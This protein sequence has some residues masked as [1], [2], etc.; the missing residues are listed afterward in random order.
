MLRKPCRLQT[1]GRTDGQTDGRGESSIPP[2]PPSS[3]GGGIKMSTYII[4]RITSCHQHY[5]PQEGFACVKKVCYVYIASGALFVPTCIVI[6]SS[7]L[8]STR[9]S[10]R[11]FFYP[12]GSY[13]S[14][15]L[16]IWDIGYTQNIRYAST[17]SGCKCGIDGH[18]LPKQLFCTLLFSEV[19]SI[20]E[21]HANYWISHLYLIGVAATQLPQIL[22]MHIWRLSRIFTYQFP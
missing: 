18:V 19:F 5:R 2:P 10:D 7:F 12:V 6:V 14:I 16:M 17:L 22:S 11:R 8:P 20:A 15:R 13:R 9:W 3:L 1:D 21:T 4:C